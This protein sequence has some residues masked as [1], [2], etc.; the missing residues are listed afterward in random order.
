MITYYITVPCSFYCQHANISIIPMTIQSINL[1][2]NQSTFEEDSL[3]EQEVSNM[4]VG[5]LEEGVDRN[6]VVA[7][8]HI[9]KEAVAVDPTDLELMQRQLPIAVLKAVSQR[10]AIP[11]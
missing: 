8:A 10:I 6:L 7:A 1:T 9:P 11:R 3:E 4:L 5:R 2:N